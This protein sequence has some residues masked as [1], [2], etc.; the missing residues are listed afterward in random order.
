MS[1]LLEKK[2][3]DY[4]E[5]GHNPSPI[6]QPAQTRS[7]PLDQSSERSKFTFR[8]YWFDEWVRADWERLTQP[9][10][11]KRLQVLEIGCFEGA[12]TT[13]ILDNLMSH[14]L[15]TLT[16]VDTFELSMEH[17]KG[18]NSGKYDVATLE[19]RFRA[20]VAKCEQAGKLEVM[21]TKSEEALVKL[22]EKGARFDFIYI[23]ASHA[24]FDVLHDAVVSWPMLNLN[25]TMVFDD[26][27]WKGFMEDC[28]NPRIAIQAFLHC[29]A[30]E[31]KSERVKSQIWV[32][33]VTNHIHP[34][35]N[36][37]PELYYWDEEA[38]LK[39]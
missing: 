22:R 7:S 17:K 30:P 23:D 12:S 29:A 18:D 13:W 5:S 37:D 4:T 39:M 8:Y 14:P 36:P 6:D 25:G 15:S 38:G 31:L 28:Y 34:T 10:R 3:T 11:G 21:K 1:P 16:S 27:T 19:D 26:F 32:T 2:Q 9:L 35:P 24:A 20:N 33:K